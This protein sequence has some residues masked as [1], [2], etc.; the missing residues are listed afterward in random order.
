METW[1]ELAKEIEYLR[2]SIDSLLEKKLE[3]QMV[4]LELRYMLKWERRVKNFYFKSTF[5]GQE[6]KDW[7]LDSLECKIEDTKRDLYWEAERAS[8]LRGEIRELKQKIND[9][10]TSIHMTTWLGE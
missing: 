2:D 3:H 10:D 1:K 6:F 4:I 8:R 5:E 7:Y 9:L